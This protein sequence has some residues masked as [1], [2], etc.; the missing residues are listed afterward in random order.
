MITL[1]KEMLSS[2]VDTVVPDDAGPGQ[3]ID[4][5][6]AFLAGAFTV[7]RLIVEASKVSKNMG[8]SSDEMGKVFVEFNRWLMDE[9]SLSRERGE[10]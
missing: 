8:K 10:R 4:T 2:Y 3:I 6:L 7:C 5:R 1:F 9:V